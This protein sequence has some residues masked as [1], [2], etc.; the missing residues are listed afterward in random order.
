MPLAEDL[1]RIFGLGGTTPSPS[2]AGAPPN[3]A[4]TPPATA[5]PAAPQ[6][7]IQPQ[8]G[9]EKF[10]SSPLLQGALDAYFT[11]VTSPRKQG[12]SEGLAR[13]GMA[14][15]QGFNQ[16]E[17]RRL[18]PVQQQAA[19]MNT[20]SQIPKNQS[21]T[22]LNQARTSA[23]IGDPAANAQLADQL[24][25]LASRQETSPQK[26][27]IIGWIL[28]AVK[29]G[30]IKPEQ[31]ATL[32]ANGDVDAAKVAASQAETQLHEGEAAQLPLKGQQLESEIGKNQAEAGLAGARTG[33]VAPTI[34][35]LNARTGEAEA[36]TRRLSST[37]APS[38]A[39]MNSKAQT[40]L[41]KFVTIRGTPPY[42]IYGREGARK[43]WHD[44]A[45]ASMTAAGVDPATA[46]T[47][48]KAA[49]GETGAPVKGTHNGVSGSFDPATNTFT[50]DD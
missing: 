28:P 32:L 12:W 16:A 27:E 25:Q 15:L 42:N 10:L 1:A 36:Q 17:Q 29:A 45:V 37:S 41:T 26:K 5:A 20:L 49:M 35:N 48:V 11:T 13:G 9:I 4:A 40:E 47:K 38:S 6:L 19:L 43:Q 7:A 50:P 22:A 3:N 44:D 46:E 39:S 31:V 21:T 8:S 23:I 30:K 14:G 24:Q 18:Q 34:A 2:A 33:E